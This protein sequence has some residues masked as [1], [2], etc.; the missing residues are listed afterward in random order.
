MDVTRSQSASESASPIVQ[1]EAK[2]GKRLA[3]LKA[4]LACDGEAPTLGPE[5]FVAAPERTAGTQVL[6]RAFTVL[7][8]LSA[9]SRTGWRLSELAAYCGLHHATTH[10]ILACLIEE[11][12]VTRDPATRRYL[13]GRLAFEFGIAA[14]A[15]QDWKTLFGPALDRLAEQS[16]DTAFCNLRSGHESVCI[17]RREGSYPLKALTVEVGARRP[18][19]VSAGG[20]AILGKMGMAEAEAAL[21]AS[22]AYLERFPAPR[23]EAVRRMLRESQ[24]LGYGYNRE[25]IIP[26]VRA[27]GVA[28]VNRQGTPVAALSVAAVTER[29]TGARKAKVLQ[30]LAQEA[31]AIEAVL[32]AG[33]PR[34]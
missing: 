25:M 32:N 20:A 8:A 29:L 16:G 28:V 30:M 13:L 12:M 23:A 11:E 1:H 6:H 34:F 21:A 9:R 24:R 19:C 14:S 2:R 22:A 17:D 7:R 3:E 31:G 15:Q 27:L 5:L 10:R 18:L 33:G 4:P 26:G